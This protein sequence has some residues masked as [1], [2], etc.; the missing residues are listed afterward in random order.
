[1]SRRN[2]SDRA[3]GG[4]AVS[5]VLSAALVALA[6]WL[7]MP[8]AP[9]LAVPVERARKSRCAPAMVVGLLAVVLPPVV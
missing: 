2:G 7:L 5:A 3:R 1:M 9:R 8:P 4:A 6:V